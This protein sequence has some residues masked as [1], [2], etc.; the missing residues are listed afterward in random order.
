MHA[1]FWKTG[2]HSE[3]FKGDAFIVSCNSAANSS[4]F[5]DDAA[6]GL[7]CYGKSAMFLPLA[8]SPMNLGVSEP[9]NEEVL[10]C[11]KAF[12]GQDQSTAKNINR[13]QRGSSPTKYTA[14]SR[15]VLETFRFTSLAQQA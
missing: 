12:T 4:A 6:L 1:I 11:L 8:I 13:N 14:Q 5:N 15:L 9:N 3:C 2:F 10:A 7:L